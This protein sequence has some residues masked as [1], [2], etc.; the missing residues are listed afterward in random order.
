MNGFAKVAR[1]SVIRRVYDVILRHECLTRWI[2]RR[3]PNCYYCD[4]HTQSCDEEESIT[5]FATK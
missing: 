5:I 3:N 2:G 4:M 1:R